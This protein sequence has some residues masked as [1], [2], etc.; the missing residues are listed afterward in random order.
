MTRL[1]LSYAVNQLCQYMHSATIAHRSHLKRVLRYV[2][3]ILHYGLRFL[4]SASSKLHVFSD[5]LIKSLQVDLL[6]Y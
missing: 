4:K 2:K 3:G 5:L 6:C 1:D